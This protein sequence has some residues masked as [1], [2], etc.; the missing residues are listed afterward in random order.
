MIVRTQFSSNGT[1]YRASPM[2]R[3]CVFVKHKQ[4]KKWNFNKATLGGCRSKTAQSASRRALYL[5]TTKTFLAHFGFDTLRDLPNFEAFEEAG[6]LCKERVLA[7]EFGA[8][9]TQ[10]EDKFEGEA[11]FDEIE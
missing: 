10:G 4:K 7:G 5:F 11:A 1:G 3:S 6:L 8:A 9:F 2:D